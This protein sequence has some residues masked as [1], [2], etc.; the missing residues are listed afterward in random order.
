MIQQS[1]INII[2]DNNL[3]IKEV[4]CFKDNTIA[5]FFREY[6]YLH[7]FFTLGKRIMT[8]DKAR[9]L[10]ASL[11]AEQLGCSPKDIADAR[12]GSPIS[13]DSIKGIFKNTEIVEKRDTSKLFFKTS[14]A[15]YQAAKLD[16]SVDSS[17]SVFIRMIKFSNKPLF[18]YQWGQALKAPKLR[19]DWE[20]VKLQ[21]MKTILE[22]KF[23]DKLLA[24]LLKAT[25][26]KSLHELNNWGDTFWG[27]D[28]NTL[29][30]TSHLGKTLENIRSNLA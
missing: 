8:H 15:A 17:R 14:E 12:L 1:D 18:A 7:N 27:I 3:K 10:D 5:G 25:K 22:E 24:S 4:F 26:D 11:I 29:K 30:G 9:I 19:D 6:R 16:L 21:V 28:Y 2:R 23:K 20:D 13:F